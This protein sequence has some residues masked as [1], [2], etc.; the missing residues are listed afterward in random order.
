[1]KS[2]KDNGD[3]N[4]WND[5]WSERVIGAAIAVHR[6]LGPG[7][8]EQVYDT[9][10]RHELESRGVPFQSQQSVPIRYRGLVLDSG[11]RLDLVVG[12]QLVVEL[13][14]VDRVAAV[15]FSQLLSYLKLGRYPVGLLIN[16]NVPV[17]K[18]GLHRRVLHAPA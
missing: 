6:E 17:L 4:M 2:A 7:L 8:L 18:N 5:A 1:M 3:G 12:E 14:C 16:F 15:H 13:K 9:C 10:M 11:L